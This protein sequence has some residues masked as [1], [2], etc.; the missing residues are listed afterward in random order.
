MITGRAKQRADHRRIPTT[1]LGDDD[2]VGALARVHF[3]SRQTR[4]TSTAWAP[5]YLRIELRLVGV[6]EA[7][8]IGAVRKLASHCQ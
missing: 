7:L 3:A 8:M 5:A 1:L 2:G 4:A 6:E